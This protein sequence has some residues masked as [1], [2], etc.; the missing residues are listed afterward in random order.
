MHTGGMSRSNT[1]VLCVFTLHGTGPQD[2]LQS[3]AE[4]SLGRR[5]SL[6]SLY[7]IMAWTEITL[8]FFAA[9]IISVS[10]TH[11]LYTKELLT[12]IIPCVVVVGDC[13][14]T[15][16]CDVLSLATV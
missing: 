16:C 2:S 6:L 10:C 1:S 4:V 9:S 7:Q 14:T 13:I 3:Y 8:P 12:E 5:I 15:K 11:T